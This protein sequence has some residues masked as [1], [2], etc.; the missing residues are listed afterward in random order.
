MVALVGNEFFFL[1]FLERSST[2]TCFFCRDRMF[3]FLA[4][5]L[6]F[7]NDY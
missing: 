2:A 7:I 5:T 6:R 3:F 1:A 4:N